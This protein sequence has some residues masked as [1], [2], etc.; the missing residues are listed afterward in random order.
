MKSGLAIMVVIVMNLAAPV[1]AAEEQVVF[2]QSANG[3]RN[4]RPFSVADR[5]ELRWDVKG[6]TL[7]IFLFGADGERKGVLP[8]VTQNKPGSSNS[9]YPMAGSYYLKVVTEGDWTIT[10]VQLP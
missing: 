1:W 6:S 5:W 8:I 7:A 3:T 9:Y 10:V 4:T 2:S